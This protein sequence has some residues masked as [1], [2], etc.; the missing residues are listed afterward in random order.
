MSRDPI[1]ESG[2]FNLYA[3]V[4]NDPVG[5]IDRLGLVGEEAF[6]EETEPI[7][8]PIEQNVV[9]PAEA[10]IEKGAEFAWEAVKNAASSLMD[11]VRQMVNPRRAGCADLQEYTKNSF[12]NGIG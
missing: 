5:R 12:V 7:W 3:Y 8:E 1:G 4:G 6:L 2:G 9:E 10:Q 11:K